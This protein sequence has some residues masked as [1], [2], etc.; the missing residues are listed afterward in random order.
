M[1]VMYLTKAHFLTKIVN[2]EVN[3]NEW[4]Y[5]GDKPAIIN[6]YATWCSPSKT[7]TPILKELAQHYADKIC[8]YRIDVDEEQELSTAFNIRATPALLFIPINGSPQLIHGA[9]R[10]EMLQQLIEE[11]LVVKKQ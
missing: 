11:I 6:F 4:D 2:Y 8:I 7:I 9:S 1:D 10:K 5:I 3:P